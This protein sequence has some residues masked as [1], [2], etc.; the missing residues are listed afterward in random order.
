MDCVIF[1]LDG[2]LLDTSPGIMESVRFAAEKL[3]YPQPTDDQLRTFIGP[4]LTDSFMRCYGCNNEEAKKLTAAYREHYREGALLKAIPYDGIFE[5]CTE[6]KKTDFIL[7]VATS[8]PQEFS[9]QILNHF[10]FSFP[11]ICG[12]DMGGKLTKAD[13]IRKCVAKTGADRA[14]MIGDTE[15]DAKGAMETGVP[16]IAVS[17]G[18]GNPDAMMEYPHIGVANSPMDVLQILKEK[19]EN[20]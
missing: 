2:T 11:V 9:E 5:L 4:P 12:A 10:G 14:V 8:K 17:Y 1:D 16:F 18:F 15:H 20:W 13:L 7:A 19:R 6:L 3:G